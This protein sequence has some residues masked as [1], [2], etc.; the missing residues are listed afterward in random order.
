VIVLGLDPGSLHTGY[1]VI[2][3]HGSLLRAL[4]FGRISCPR[5]APVA[6]RLAL[7]CTGLEQILDR[8]TPEAAAVEAPFH[9]RNSRSLIVLAQARG[10]LLATLSRRGLV[11]AELSPAQV[12][13]AVAGYGRAEKTQVAAMV[14]LLL[15]LRDH[16]PAADSADALAVAICY[17]EHSRSLN[18]LAAQ[19]R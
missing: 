6:Q 8:W 3:R 9:G 16:L 19:G 17:A 10:A 2:E 7:L 18:R 4:D 15:G 11:P 12:K 1:G 14:C 13:S 5:T